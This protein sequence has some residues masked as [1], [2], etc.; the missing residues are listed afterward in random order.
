MTE[1]TLPFPPSANRLWRNYRGRTVISEGYRAWKEAAGWQLQSQRP[2]KH[3]GPV[4]ITIKLTLPDKRRQDID[5]RIKPIL[6]LLCAHQIIASDDSRIVKAVSISLAHGGPGASIDI[7]P[8]SPQEQT[9]GISCKTAR[10]G[11]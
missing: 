9:S 10:F 3:E 7:T 4:N 1:I 5:N 11:D 2:K 8:L 6:D